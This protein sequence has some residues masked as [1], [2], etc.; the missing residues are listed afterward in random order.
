MTGLTKDKRQQQQQTAPRGPVSSLWSS[1]DT[2][3]AQS[4]AGGRFSSMLQ[5]LTGILCMNTFCVLLTAADSEI[6]ATH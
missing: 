5:L 4:L 1:R 2:R 3:I 6:F